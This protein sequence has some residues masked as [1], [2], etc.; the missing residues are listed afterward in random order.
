MLRR[1]S[2][3]LF[4]LCI[5]SLP[6]CTAFNQKTTPLATKPAIAPHQEATGLVLS[7]EAMA[8]ELLTN[9]ADPDPDSGDMANGLVVT[10]FVESSKLHKTSSFGRYLSEQLMNEFQRHAF[11]VVEIRK[12][13][14]IRVEE[15]KG[16]FGL[17]RIEEEIAPTVKADAMLTG[18]YFVGN[19]DIIV[20]ARILNNK[21]AAL[22]ASS[23]VI[24]PKNSLTGRMLADTTSANKAAPPPLY[25]KRLEI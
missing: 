17:A 20:T 24:F 15:K 9:M 4:F 23:T 19:E 16:E 12:S 5:A 11:T 10:T 6:A 3:I 7:I 18:T 21:T 14:S 22:L 25:L 8:A 1:L 13:T 2:N